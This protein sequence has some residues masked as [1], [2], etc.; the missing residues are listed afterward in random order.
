MQS[1]VLHALKKNM[2]TNMTAKISRK[3]SIRGMLRRTTPAT[4]R[5]PPV[6]T[7]FWGFVRKYLKGKQ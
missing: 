1:V 3:L 5:V 2:M 6:N 7:I 4:Q